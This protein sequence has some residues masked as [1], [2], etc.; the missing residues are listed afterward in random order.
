M[1]NGRRPGSSAETQAVEKICETI[2][3]TE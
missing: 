1:V 2:A 3:A